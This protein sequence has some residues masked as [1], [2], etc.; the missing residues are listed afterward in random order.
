MIS[1]DSK[2]K[3]SVIILCLFMVLTLFMSINSYAALPEPFMCKNRHLIFVD[4]YLYGFKEGT[5]SSDIIDYFYD[6]KNIVA[7]TE[8]LGT[9]SVLSYMD[10]DSVVQNSVTVV[11]FG[12]LNGDG[13]VSAVDYIMIKKGV[14]EPDLLSEASFRAGDI[15]GDGILKAVD[16]MRVKRHIQGKLDI[17]DCS[18][19]PEPKEDETPDLT[20]NGTLIVNGVDITEG[21]YVKFY[22]DGCLLR[23]DIPFMAIFKALGGEVEAVGSNWCDMYINNT[24]VGIRYYKYELEVDSE[25]GEFFIE[26]YPVEIENDFVVEGYSQGLKDF[27]NAF[28]VEIEVDNTNNIVN[29]YTIE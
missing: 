1:A 15:S 8:K 19:V 2:Y 28:N 29:I 16:Y 18:N 12:D 27:L 24:Y 11:I 25:K 5:T 17:N 22:N 6:Y 3:K 13:K 20:S 10:E 4:D 9:G 7:S 14:L 21:N 26:A 23:L